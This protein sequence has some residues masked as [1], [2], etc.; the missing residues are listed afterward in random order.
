MLLKYLGKILRLPWVSGLNIPQSL[1]LLFMKHT[2]DSPCN[3]EGERALPLSGGQH[4][5]KPSI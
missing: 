3:P 4:V 2:D 1:L 5:Y